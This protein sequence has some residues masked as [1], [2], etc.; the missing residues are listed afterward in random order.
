MNRELVEVQEFPKTRTSVDRDTS[1]APFD[2]QPDYSDYR[3]P[4]V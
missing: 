1:R 2:E 3:D 4:T